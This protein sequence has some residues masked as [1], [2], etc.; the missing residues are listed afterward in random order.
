MS[1]EDLHSV[2]DEA[3]RDSIYNPHSNPVDGKD[4]VLAVRAGKDCPHCP[5]SATTSYEALGQEIGRLVQ[6][7]Q[8]QY[9][10]SFGQAHKVL[11]ALYPS[12]VRPDQYSDILAVARIVD[13]LFR[14]AQRG[15]D[16]AD[17]GG[18]SPFQDIV[19]YG[20]LGLAKD[21]AR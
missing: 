20:I 11:A 17:L 8:L 14:I 1:K 5:Q 16:G 6:S 19:G 10:D 12:G 13:K 15:A 3:S 9:G 4:H 2:L 18:E 21:R 7:K